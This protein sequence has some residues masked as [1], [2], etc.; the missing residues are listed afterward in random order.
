MNEARVFDELGNAQLVDVIIGRL[1]AR[2]SDLSNIE[3]D[4]CRIGALIVDDT[5]RFGG[6]VPEVRTLQI[7]RAQ[8]LVSE[9]SGERIQQWLAS[10][11]SA[12]STADVSD[13]SR[14]CDLPLVKFFD[15]VCRRFMRQHYI[16]DTETDDGSALLHDQYWPEV[17]EILDDGN[18]IEIQ[19]RRGSASPS[20]RRGGE[21]YHV[22]HPERLLFPEDDQESQ[23]IRLAIIARAE[24]LTGGYE[25]PSHI[26]N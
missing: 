20:G 4:K 2:G 14:G 15:R 24:E 21:F 10:H 13:W 9:R 11:S 17:L 22:I 26:P 3:F 25:E 19:S 18:R 6:S 23:K 7:D 12:F 1:D 8:S 16:R 5:T